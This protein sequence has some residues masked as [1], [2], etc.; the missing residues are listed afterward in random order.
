MPTGICCSR[1][2]LL[3]TVPAGLKTRLMSWP[4]C[5]LEPPQFSLALSIRAP[6]LSMPAGGRFYSLAHFKYCKRRCTLYIKKGLTTMQYCFVHQT[7]PWA[8][9]VSPGT[10]TCTALYFENRLPSF[11]GEVLLASRRHP[12]FK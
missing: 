9:I 11:P 1:V 4:F 12:V 2:R 8:L 6:R 5:F 3:E 7:Q 10:Q